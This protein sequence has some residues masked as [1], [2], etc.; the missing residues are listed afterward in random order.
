MSTPYPL[1]RCTQTEPNTFSIY[2]TEEIFG[3]TEKGFAVVETLVAFIV[4]TPG[5]SDG[6][7]RLGLRVN[8]RFADAFENFAFDNEGEVQGLYLKVLQRLQAVAEGRALLVEATK[9]L[10]AAP[11]ATG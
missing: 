4:L 10:P 9:L 1:S 6:D 8:G 3:D 11:D 2:L 7:V 5:P